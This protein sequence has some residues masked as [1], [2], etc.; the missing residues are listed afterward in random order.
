MNLHYSPEAIDD[1]SRL[2]EFIEEK[3]PMA[4]QKA[5]FNYFERY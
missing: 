4:A 2:R 3:N 5:A 1:L